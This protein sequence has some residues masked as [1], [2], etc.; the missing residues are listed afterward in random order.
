M[1]CVHPSCCFA[2]VAH[3][4]RTACSWELTWKAANNSQKKRW[5]FLARNR[6][7]LH[8][9]YHD[10]FPLT[11]RGLIEK[12]SQNCSTETFQSLESVLTITA[13]STVQRRRCRDS[14]SGE[15]HTA[16]CASSTLVALSR[17]EFSFQFAECVA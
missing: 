10:Q 12:L 15:L 3:I 14:W 5:H 4:P 8:C 13:L 1:D 7:A 11:S 17:F 16:I 9:G 6:C 2:P